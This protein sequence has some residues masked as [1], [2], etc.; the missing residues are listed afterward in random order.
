MFA[1][2]RSK[3]EVKAE[4]VVGGDDFLSPTR[5]SVVLLTVFLINICRNKFALSLSFFAGCSR[6]DCKEFRELDFLVCVGKAG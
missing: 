6:E 3:P 4:S 5:F 2:W 1:S